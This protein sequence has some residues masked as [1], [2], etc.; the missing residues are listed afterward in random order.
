[1]RIGVTAR[2]VM[3]FVFI[4]LITALM[5]GLVILELGDLRESLRLATP[6]SASAEH[7]AS[8][9]SVTS[10]LVAVVVL[11]PLVCLL[12]AAL[13]ALVLRRSVFAPVARIG[14]V[15]DAHARGAPVAVPAGGDDAIGRMAGALALL[16]RRIDAREQELRAHRDLLARRVAERT[17]E[18]AGLREELSRA[19]RL[20]ALGEFAASVAHEVNQPL[21]AI[22]SNAQAARRH[23]DGASPDLAEVRAALDAVIRN[24]RRASEVVRELRALVM[25]AAAGADTGASG[26]SAGA[27][28]SLDLNAVVAE[29][30]ALAEGEAGP[31][32]DPIELR[33]GAALPPVRGSKTQLQ[34]VLLNLVTNARDALRRTSPGPG[35]HE[36]PAGDHEGPA[37]VVWTERVGADLVVGVR[38]RGPGL[39][40]TALGRVFEPFYTTREGGMGMGLAI[41]KTIVETHGGRL[42]AER[43]PDRGMTF[44]FSLPVT[45]P[46]AILRTAAAQPAS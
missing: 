5:S 25:G 13:S 42:W 32:G 36:G 1:M 27:L 14:R 15:M 46:P 31:D 9:E 3:G 12:A 35:D 20:A 6:A 4:A 16:I 33:P 34:Q 8:L 7:A 38:D 10:H 21:A 26:A 29:V 43:N 2:I 23:L 30:V 40:D 24:D 11:V 19:G 37:L 22:L 18:L 28:A 39:D 44:Q 17:A 45:G 41:A